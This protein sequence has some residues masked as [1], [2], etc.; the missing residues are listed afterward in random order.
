MLALR[1][2][3]GWSP[4]F[5]ASRS[6]TRNMGSVPGA[7]LRALVLL[8]V[9]GGG[10]AAAGDTG[11]HADDLQLAWGSPKTLNGVFI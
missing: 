8:S 10:S 1:A 4:G 5:G 2:A 11:K 6:R 7:V 3:A 9:Q